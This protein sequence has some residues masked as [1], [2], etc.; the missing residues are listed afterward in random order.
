M[1]NE[2]HKMRVM[3]KIF[4]T[5]N[6]C[7]CEE[8]NDCQSVLDLGC[9]PSSP[10]QY[11]KSI[12]Y[13]VGVEAFYPYL[14]QSR[15]KGIHTTY[16]NKRIE[17]IEFEENSFDAVIM[18]EVLEHLSEAMGLDIINRAEK[19]AKKKVI[20]SSPNGFL[21]QGILDDNPLQTHLSGWD[22][23]T[24]SGLGFRSRGLAGLKYL[25]Q[26]VKGDTMGDDLTAS[27]KYDPKIFWFA[28]AAISQIFTYY[29]PQYAFELI[30]V[31]LKKE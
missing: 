18:I 14:K 3:G 5:L 30:S 9:G 27:I 1:I 7:L 19:W 24:M 6:Y 4:H 11:C 13:S 22:G 20:V 28:V 25:R 17:D 8:L 23:R 16:L 15:E 12:K 29:F 10:I 31:K 21:E 2:L 26:E